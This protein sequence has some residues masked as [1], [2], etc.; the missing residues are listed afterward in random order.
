M[1]FCCF[2]SQRCSVART[3]KQILTDVEMST[4]AASSAIV[5]LAGGGEHIALLRAQTGRMSGYPSRMLRLAKSCPACRPILSPS[6]LPAFFPWSA[7]Y[8]I[9]GN[10]KR[11]RGRTV[12]LS[13]DLFHSVLIQLASGSVVR[14]SIFSRST[15][16]DLRLMYA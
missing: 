8:D 13:S 15:F 16:P 2:F 14:T 5:A 4:R 1:Q 9:S 3:S 11:S 10:R 7:F 6:H 12:F